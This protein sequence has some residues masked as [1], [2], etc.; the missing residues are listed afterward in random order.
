MEIFFN[1]R[2][3]FEKKKIFELIDRRLIEPGGDYICVAD[4]NILTNV[5]QS[6]TYRN[7]INE[8][9]FSISDS[10]WTPIFI[11][12]I[13]GINRKS[14]TGSDIFK[15]LLSSKKYHMAFLG[16][17]EEALIGLDTYLNDISYPTDKRFFLELP[18]KDVTG[19]DYENI[20]EVLNN[21]S[22]DIIWVGL[23]APKQEIFMNKLKPYLKRGIMIGVGAVFNF[24][25]NTH[26]KR[27]P[28]FIRKLHLEFLHRIITEPNKQ[29]PK[30]TN[31]IRTLPHIL[32]DEY[33][34][35]KQNRQMP[36]NHQ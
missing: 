2:F 28:S 11:R 14:Y 20:A 35:K 34:V 13:Y 1:I 7:I 31:Y 15:A 8:G 25:G 36:K 16:G 5:H 18:F 33:R 23:G 12:L 4:G 6:V 27:A 32:H 9:L 22:I 29:V 21:N 3:E 26:I 30:F 17:T 24:Y 10:S 19:F